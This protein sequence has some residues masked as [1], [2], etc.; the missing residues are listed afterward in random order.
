MSGVSSWLLISL[1][2]ITFVNR[3]AFFTET[4]RFT[5]GAKIRKLLSYSSYAVLTAIWMPIIFQFKAGEGL[6]V[7]GL[8]YLLGVI[9]A[10][11]LTMLKVRSI[12]VVLCSTGLF[13][14]LRFLVIS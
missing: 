7:A 6:S 1:A 10:A 4:I 9:L 5:P 2:L 12:F 8:D 13:F 11:L 14:M 3:F